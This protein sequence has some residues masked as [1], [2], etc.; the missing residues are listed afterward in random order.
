MD[1]NGLNLGG[2]TLADEGL[3]LN[4]ASE[5]ASSPI[6]EHCL[7]GR[8][9]A[10]R[11]IKFA[12]FA[13]RM[14]STW[15]P[16]KRVTILQ[17]E[18]ERYL[19]QFHHKMDATKVLDDGPW[20]YDNF[21]LVAEK[22][23]PGVVPS[24]VD[25]NHMDMWVQV[26]FLPFG[27]IQQ[28]VG[29]G[30]DQFLGE[31]KAYDIWN[32][33]HSSY[34]RIKV[35]LDVTQPLKKEWRVRVNDGNYVPV[36]FKYEKL[37]VFCYICGL[38]GHT[39]KVCPELFEINSDDGVRGWGP[40]LKP[41][42]HRVGTSATNKWLQ[43]LIPDVNARGSA[44]SGEQQMF[45]DSSV[46]AAPNLSNLQGRMMVVHQEINSLKQYFLV[47]QNM[48]VA[49]NEAGSS[50]MTPVPLLNS[51]SAGLSIRSLFLPA[52]LFLDCLQPLCLSQVYHALLVMLK[53]MLWIL[54]QR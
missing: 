52:L 49:R 47:P 37:G 54:V 26:H 42:A 31:F 5:I 46:G 15:K 53:M 29:Q 14:A 6:L 10:D 45:D 17:A 1:P 38:I 19:F 24:S 21:H 4:L 51:S 9:L 22:I 28:R 48:M 33:A 8:V 2:L 25:L 23:A 11:Q 40:D 16:V 35:K 41:V 32:T 44:N 36:F 18:G 20:L 7:I 13:E 12:Y 30:I 3:T 34:M 39:D 50:S 27:F 43:D